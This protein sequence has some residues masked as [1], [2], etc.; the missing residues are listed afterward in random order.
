MPPRFHNPLVR[1]LAWVAASPA[2]LDS[3]LLPMRDPLQDSIWRQDPDQLW[4]ELSALDAARTAWPRYSA[5]RQIGALAAIT[6][7]SGTLC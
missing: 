6:S 5:I 3:Q 2:L 7:A 4:H 1:D